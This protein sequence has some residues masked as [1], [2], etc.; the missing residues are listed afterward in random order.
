MTKI[1]LI[2]QRSAVCFRHLPAPLATLIILAVICSCSGQ[3]KPPLRIGTHVWPGY[4]PLY[5]ARN[6]GFL[7]DNEVQLVEY[8]SA[9]EVIR[10]FR[11]RAI[12]GA[13][14]TLDEVLLLAQ[15][16][17]DPRVVLVTDISHGGDVILGRPGMKNLASLQGRRIGVENNALLANEAIT[18]FDSSQI[19]G[20]IVDVL[21]IRADLAKRRT[22]SVRNLLKGWFQ[23][24]GF[25]ETKPTVAA[26]F[27]AVR[28]QISAPEVLEALKGI[29][30]PT[31]E[32][33]RTLIGGDS[34]GLAKS[35]NR[36]MEI[37]LK[38]QLL[39]KRVDPNT[40]F[41]PETLEAVRP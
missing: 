10:A 15:D 16:G 26:E 1:H 11:N 17:L 2:R 12:D 21:V 41:A 30:F 7:D 23:A 3:P 6:R 13:T 9:S 39:L 19:P 25:L 27:M 4:E 37:M 38:N 28:L 40:L 32:E 22:K 34:P 8:P 35:G 14:L 18:L 36:L 24:L 31:L 29:R 20:E 5:L 33:S